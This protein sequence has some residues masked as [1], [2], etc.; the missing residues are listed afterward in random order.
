MRDRRSCRR[1]VWN[2][3]YVVNSEETELIRIATV[4]RGLRTLD[5]VATFVG[6][7]LLTRDSRCAC[8]ADGF[9]MFRHWYAADVARLLERLNSVAVT[10]TSCP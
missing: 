6:D 5:D 10:M 4:E 3:D 9:G 1:L 7:E 8:F 2:D